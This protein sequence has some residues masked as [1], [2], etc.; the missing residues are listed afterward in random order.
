MIVFLQSW[1]NLIIALAALIVA[2]LSLHKSNQ[3]QKLQSKI[4]KHELDKIA[5]EKEEESKTLVDVNIIEIKNR[6]YKLRVSNVSKQNVY[7]VNVSIDSQYGIFILTNDIVPFEI[8]EP[9]QKFDLTLVAYAGSA[10]KFDVNLT[11]KDKDGKEYN[12]TV[13]RTL[14]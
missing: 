10:P 5:K 2:I 7:N 8:L 14:R 11:W 3:A 6:Q 12:K 13:I 1:G 9:Y 4:N